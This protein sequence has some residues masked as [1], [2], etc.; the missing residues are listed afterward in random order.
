MTWSLYVRVCADCHTVGLSL[1]KHPLELLRPTLKKLRAVTAEGLKK[2]PSGRRGAVGGMPICQQRPPTAKGIYFILLEG[3]T[4]L[5]T[6]WSPRTCGGSAGEKSTEPSSWR[7][8][9]AGAHWKG[10][11]REDPDRGVPEPVMR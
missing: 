5:R 10:D 1:E 3:E 8:G 7:R 4:G 9:R 11:E 2:E 6:W